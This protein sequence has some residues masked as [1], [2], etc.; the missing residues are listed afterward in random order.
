MASA[1]EMTFCTTA[2]TP[3]FSADDLAAVIVNFYKFY[4]LSLVHE[5]IAIFTSVSGLARG[6][7]DLHF[8]FRS[9][10]TVTDAFSSHWVPPCWKSGRLH[11]TIGYR[12]DMGYVTS[13][14]S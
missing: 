7:C 12:L 13:Q 6:H 2:V 9:C 11:Y 3:S 5:A 8:G 10:T 1:L 4:S 14:S